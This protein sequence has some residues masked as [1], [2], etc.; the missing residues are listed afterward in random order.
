M[1]KPLQRASTR[2]SGCTMSEPTQI[3][4]G[5][6]WADDEHQ[7]VYVVGFDARGD[8]VLDFGEGDVDAVLPAMLREY[9]TL[10]RD[11]Q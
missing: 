10:I 11:V 7:T 2:I 6:V 1:R 3:C 9:Y 5:Q 8:V 4:S